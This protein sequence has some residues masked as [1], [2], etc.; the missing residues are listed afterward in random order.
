MNQAGDYMQELEPLLATMTESSLSQDQRARLCEILRDHPEAQRF[1]KH[2]VELHAMLEWESGAIVPAG[3]MGDEFSWSLIAGLDDVEDSARL[4]DITEEQ[5]RREAE[6]Q[7]RLQHP[8]DEAA[9]VVRQYVIPRLAIYGGVAAAVA[10]AVVLLVNLIGPGADPAGPGADHF[11]SEAEPPTLPVAQVTDELNAAWRLD[12]APKE[13]PVGSK[14][15]PSQRLTLTR[16]F[17]E[18]TT[19]RGAVALLEAPCTIELTG[20][21]NALRLHR[22]RLVGTCETPASRGFV[23]QT[24]QARIIDLG[25]SFGVQA[26]P[27]AENMVHVFEGEV[28]VKP[29]GRDDAHQPMRTLTKGQSLDLDD[30]AMVVRDMMPGRIA[31]VRRIEDVD[32]PS[33]KHTRDILALGPVAYWPLTEIEPSGVYPSLVGGPS[34]NLELQGRGL[35]LT[36]GPLTTASAQANAIRL[37]GDDTYFVATGFQRDLWKDNEYS[38]VMWVR[39]T[40]S[41]PQNLFALTTSEQERGSYFSSQLR[42]L[43]SGQVEHYSFQPPD[44]NPELDDANPTTHVAR[45]AEPLTTNQWVH[46]CATYGKGSCRLYIDGKLVDVTSL[47]L[48]FEPGYPTLIL[49]G[50]TG[51]DWPDTELNLMNAFKGGLCHVALLNR[52]LSAEDIQ[53]LAGSNAGRTP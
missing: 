9:A 52:T 46:I 26:A 24:D 29:E 47:D 11:A 2:Y 31:F 14:L 50:A 13:L 1:Y 30:P 12:N 27:G 36:P 23:V 19:G 6:R 51:F 40:G 34:R 42:I 15:W 4:V 38:I 28:A 8:P 25:T 21:D 32:S 45:S 44:L 35:G 18:I 49:G 20:S 17:A 48:R 10:L 16:G 33:L 3:P 5:R 53:T 22:G 41:G 37:A 43:G 7:R 39:A